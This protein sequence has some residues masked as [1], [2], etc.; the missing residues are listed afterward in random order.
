MT[1][2]VGLIEDNTIYLG[3]DSLGSNGHSK[4]EYRFPKVFQNGDFL[5]GYTSSFRMGQM[6]QY[7]LDLSD[8]HPKECWDCLGALVKEV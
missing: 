3:A 8:I 2:V 1:C 4:S 5:I 7:E 6:L